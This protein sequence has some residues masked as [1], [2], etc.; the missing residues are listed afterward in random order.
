MRNNPDII[1]RHVTEH[2]MCICNKIHQDVF[3]I[4]A[5][6]V[7]KICISQWMQYGELVQS[8]A[9]NC[10]LI[11]WRSLLKYKWGNRWLSVSLATNVLW[12]WGGLAPDVACDHNGHV[13][14][15]K[16]TGFLILSCLGSSG[17]MCIRTFP[18]LF[19]PVPVFFFFLIWNLKLPESSM[20]FNKGYWAQEDRPYTVQ[21]LES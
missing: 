14:C 18:L 5:L 21:Q 1:H 4:R 19:K 17:V 10:C 3:Y 12:L 20:T 15:W 11:V 16:E 2:V 9:Q 13:E 7:W 6:T 8:E